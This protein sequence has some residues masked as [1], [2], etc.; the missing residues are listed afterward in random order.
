M[1]AGPALANKIPAAAGGWSC[2]VAPAGFFCPDSK[3]FTGKVSLQGEPLATEPA[4]SLG[5]IDTIVRRL[6]DTTFDAKGEG[7]TR[8]Q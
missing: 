7:R 1:R 8:I 4:G 6:D 2:H 5:K 3:P